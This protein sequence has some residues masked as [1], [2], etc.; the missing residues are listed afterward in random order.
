MARKHEFGSFSLMKTGGV[1]GSSSFLATNDQA[2]MAFLGVAPF[3][4]DSVSR[5]KLG[6]L[7]AFK[8]I[9]FLDK[10]AP[11]FRAACV[12]K[13][14]GNVTH[15]LFNSLVLSF[16][17]NN[18]SDEFAANM[19]DGTASRQ[20]IG[21]RCARVVVIGNALQ[22]MVLVTFDFLALKGD[23]EGSAV[24]FSSA[25]TQAG[26]G[27]G[28]DEIGFNSTVDGVRAY[29]IEMMREQLPDYQA[30]ATR[31][32]KRIESKAFAGLFTVQRDP[33]G[34]ITPSTGSTVRLGTTPNG[35]QFI[36]SLDRNQLAYP[37]DPSILGTETREYELFNSAGGSNITI[38]SF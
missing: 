24:T 21:C 27:V 17:G 6:N 38:S 10:K 7:S 15:K 36:M 31:Y 9:R 14:G 37:L 8:S 11:G 13:I 26:Q 1:A 35:I 23:N 22:G 16:D 29:S 2:D 25:T 32:A 34:A 3:N 20:Y 4:P 5:P 33:D 18:N 12:L 28:V 30:D 19:S